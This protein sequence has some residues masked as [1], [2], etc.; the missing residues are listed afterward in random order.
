MTLLCRE[1]FEQ[2]ASAHLVLGRVPERYPVDEG[3]GPSGKVPTPRKKKTEICFF[4]HFVSF[5]LIPRSGTPTGRWSS[6]SSIWQKNAVSVAR[7]GFQNEL[8]EVF[9][10]S[11]LTLV[12]AWCINNFHVFS[13]ALFLGHFKSYSTLELSGSFLSKFC[14]QNW[15]L[16][17]L[18]SGQEAPK[19]K[20]IFYG[21]CLWT[22]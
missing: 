14:A 19:M 20:N 5:F 8:L 10:A 21:N 16:C 22:N 7:R 13:N 11:L 1:S 18:F 15:G 12:A 6:S 17:S 2:G 4:P 9:G 3:V